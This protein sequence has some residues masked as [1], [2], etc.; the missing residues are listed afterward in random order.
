MYVMLS[1]VLVIFSIPFNTFEEF[2]PK[3]EVTAT[4]QYNSYQE[5]Y[6]DVLLN[7]YG[8]N[9]SNVRFDLAYIDG[10]EPELIVAEDSYHAV[11]AKVYSYKD[12]KLVHYL[13]QS[14]GDDFGEYGSVHYVEGRGY[15]VSDYRGMGEE[16]ME[17]YKIG[18]SSAS[19]EHTFTV[20][21][22]TDHQMEYLGIDDIPNNNAEQYYLYYDGSNYDY[23]SGYLEQNIVSYDT[24]KS[25][26][27]KYG[28]LD[29]TINGGDCYANTS[30]GYEDT[31]GLSLV[32][33]DNMYPLNQTNL[34]NLLWVDDSTDDDSNDSTDGDVYSNVIADYIN[35][36]SASYS[37]VDLDSNG[38]LELIVLHGKSEATKYYEIY[39]ADGYVGQILAMH[40]SLYFNSECMCTSA[41]NNLNQTIYEYYLDNLSG[42]LLMEQDIPKG[43]YDMYGY[44][45][46]NHTLYKVNFKSISEYTYK[47]VPATSPTGGMSLDEYLALL[48]QYNNPNNTTFNNTKNK[49]STQYVTD[50]ADLN[51]IINN[52]I[53]NISVWWD[54]SLSDNTKVTFLDLDFDGELEFV[55]SDNQ[56]NGDYTYTDY[57]RVTKDTFQEVT[58]NGTSFKDYTLLPDILQSDNLQLYLVNKVYTYTATDTEKYDSSQNNVKQLEF[59]Y[60]TKSK[61]LKVDLCYMLEKLSNGTVYYD[62]SLNEIS[63]ATYNSLQN[64][65]NATHNDANN[66]NLKYEW[67]SIP[68]NVTTLAK[69]LVEAYDAFSYDVTLSPDSISILYDEEL[70]TDGDYEYIVLNGYAIVAKYLG[71]SSNVT[72][73]D[74]LGDYPV[75]AISGI[76]VP[77]ND[78]Q[79]MGAFEDVENLSSVTIPSTVQLIGDYAFLGCNRLEEVDF[80]TKLQSIGS[81]AFSGCTYLSSLDLSSTG[82]V[83]IYEGAFSGCTNLTDVTFSEL[84]QN[85]YQEAFKDCP[86]LKEVSIPKNVT[87]A[88]DKSF[89][90]LNGEYMSNFKMSIY[91]FNPYYDYCTTNNLQFEWVYDTY[92][93]YYNGVHYYDISKLSNT[94]YN[95]NYYYSNSMFHDIVYT[96]A[97]DYQQGEL[98][99]AKAFDTV[100]DTLSFDF[101]SV[102]EDIESVMDTSGMN[103][104]TN[105]VIYDSMLRDLIIDMVNEETIVNDTKLNIIDI[106]DAANQAG[107][108]SSSISNAF[109]STLKQV[110]ESKNLSELYESMDKVKDFAQNIESKNKFFEVLGSSYAESVIDYSNDIQDIIYSASLYNSCKDV[111]NDIYQ[112]I[113]RINKVATSAGYD[114]LAESSSNYMDAIEG[115][116]FSTSLI[117]AIEQSDGSIASDLMFDALGEKMSKFL[118]KRIPELAEAQAIAGIWD[119]F[120]KGLKDTEKEELDIGYFLACNSVH[121]IIYSALEEIH[122]DYDSSNLEYARVTHM[123]FKAYTYTDNIAYKYANEFITLFTKNNIY[124]Q[125]RFIYGLGKE[126]DISSLKRTLGYG[127]Y[128]N[129]DFS[130]IFVGLKDTLRKDL[131]RLNNIN[132]CDSKIK[133]TFTTNDKL[134][135]LT[136]MCPVNVEVYDSTNS[137]IAT[138][139]DED[140][141]CDNEYMGYFSIFSELDSDDNPLSTN[142]KVALLPEDYTY[143]LVATDNGSMSIY[144]QTIYYSDE[145]STLESV[146]SFED[147]PLNQGDTFEISTDNNV[148]ILTNTTTGET[149]TSTT[150]T[151][152]RFSS[153]KLTII[154]A[155][156]VLVLVVVI[157][158]IIFKHNNR[159]GRYSRKGYQIIQDDLS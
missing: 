93:E 34:D 150:A 2:L 97:W 138:I 113:S 108:F 41:I 105:K 92:E 38:S 10:N 121:S 23:D 83:S 65:F 5:A 95:S 76:Q 59:Y 129:T 157:I 69:D 85:V 48:S 130:Y 158:L 72:I 32:M 45:D 19:L 135:K 147:I 156:I 6:R 30:N 70:Y 106:L 27:N 154:I 21:F 71:S 80:P 20:E 132:C 40:A 60:D 51:D 62:S 84:L 56:G 141:I 9:T 68:N 36:S 73:P 131:E 96:M 35:D 114:D 128:S 58:V 49:Y 43:F 57:Y 25:M 18:N 29:A 28:I 127:E 155:V 125:H 110:S 119:T 46:P 42:K 148:Y 152:S 139:S 39:T 117:E 47:E 15:I 99:M 107:A 7:T 31:T 91:Y 4:K 53:S 90:Y 82:V 17:I 116:E 3:F 50:N 16:N 26:L 137:L 104:Y 100:N 22:S 81:Y 66:L 77:E 98:V 144:N 140:I 134:N 64:D 94:Y 37:L 74:T 133:D 87:T 124:I 123:L 75:G 44:Y 146:Y 126:F 33:Y 52:I 101:D 109:T 103:Q 111:S 12:G 1:L 122:A 13:N 61:A 67:V 78:Y 145:D 89:G 143:R 8:V 153:K 54:D 112:M 55:V 79:T 63:Q 115:K 14:G 24:F 142:A 86:K 151:S 159:G 88:G 11:G 118:I 149:Y 120:Y 102:K 136:I